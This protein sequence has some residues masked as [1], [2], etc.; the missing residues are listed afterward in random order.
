MARNARLTV[1]MAIAIIGFLGMT[2]CGGGNSNNSISV[3]VTPATASVPIN[4]T[5]TFSANVVG[6][7]NTAVTW[8]ATGGGT[9]DSS[10]V[11]TAP[12]A[13]PSGSVTITATSQADTKVTGTATVTVTSAQGITVTPSGITLAAGATQAFTANPAA[14]VAWSV[15]GLVGGDCVAPPINSTTQ[16]HGTIS[17]AG[18]YVA[19]LSPPTGQTVTIT[20]AGGGNSGTATVTIKF[21]SASL[22]T[23]GTTGQYALALT[24]VDFLQGFPIDIAG[25]ITTAGSPGSLAGMITGGEIDINSGTLGLSTA[26]Q[27]TGGTFTVLDKGLTGRT[28]VT[29]TTA[30]VLP[31][32]TLQV[33]IASNQHALMIDFDTSDTGSGT[34]DA[35]NATSFSTLFTGN[36]SF[37]LSGIDSAN[38]NPLVIAGT[39]QANNG[40][41]PVNSSTAPVNVQDFEDISFSTPIVTDDLSLSGSYTAADANGRGTMALTSST[42]G[43]INLAYYMTDQTHFKVVEIDPS[44]T[45]IVGGDVYSAPT[46]PTGLS[47]GAALTF[48]GLANGAP[49]AGAAGFSISGSSGVL[50]INNSGGSSSQANNPIT[51]VSYSNTTSAGSVPAR[52]MLSLTTNRGTAMFAAYTFTTPSATGAEIVEIDNNTQGASGTAY[53]QGS[54]GTPQGSFSLNLTGIGTSKSAG[55]FEQ[56]LT[57]ELVLTANSTTPSGSLDFNNGAVGGP[58]SALGITSTSTFAAP[59]S[60]GRG[61]MQLNASA[62]GHSATFKLVYYVVDASTVLILDADNNR[63]ANGVLARQF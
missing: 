59:A 3:T 22:T 5:Q 55:S 20:A 18:S 62:S 28:A 30:G 25:S 43:T 2:G 50:D 7:S 56:D 27:V 61:T 1:F 17:A 49:Y 53:Q 38:I 45:Y 21:S 15:N 42:L 16:C 29:L 40:S 23:N 48:G 9:I 37:G 60:N 31:S 39:F 32:I 51:S 14:G 24:G 10:G 8:T 12:S 57:G 46:T 4:Q 19:P 35:Q 47:G 58:F 34:L 52:Y 26:T 44:Q 36:F 33:T 54:T 11:Y 41:I 13:V 63:V 6:T